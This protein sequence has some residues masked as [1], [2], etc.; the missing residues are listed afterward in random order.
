LTAVVKSPILRKWTTALS[1]QEVGEGNV[2][3]WT[4]GL[5]LKW[6]RKGSEGRDVDSGG[7]VPGN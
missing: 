7:R 1:A 2:A 3:W 5:V 4:E 6:K